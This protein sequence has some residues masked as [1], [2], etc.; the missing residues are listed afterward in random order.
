M[1]G[2]HFSREQ[3]RSMVFDQMPE[4]AILADPG[5]IVCPWNRGAQALSGFTMLKPSAPLNV[6]CYIGNGSTF[7]PGCV[8]S[9]RSARAK[10]VAHSATGTP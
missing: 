5:G 4:A 9:L 10:I 8:L 6:S 7:P 3:L 1:A 2:H